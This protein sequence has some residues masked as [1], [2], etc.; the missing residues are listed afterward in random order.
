[1]LV[2]LTPKTNY[3]SALVKKLGNLWE[4]LDVSLG[5]TVQTVKGPIQIQPAYKIHSVKCPVYSLMGQI[6]ENWLWLEI[7]D[8]DFEWEVVA[9]ESVT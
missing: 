7:E 1:M 5:I 8:E 9:H 3:G 4:V 2:H 6:F